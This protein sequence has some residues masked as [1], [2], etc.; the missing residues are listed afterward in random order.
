AK[1]GSVFDCS[2]YIYQVFTQNGFKG[3]PGTSET[4]WATHSGPNWTSTGIMPNSAQPGDVVFMVGSPEYPSPGHVGIVTSG[5]GQNAQV[6]QYYSSG[7]PADTIPMSQI[8][9]MVGIKRFYLVKKEAGAGA[10]TPPAG[11]S[12]AASTASTGASGLVVGKAAKKP[13]AQPLIPTKFGEAI[14]AAALTKGV[15]DDIKAYNSAINEVSQAIAGTKKGSESRTKL[16][17][18]LATY[19]DARNK[20]AAPIAEAAIAK[21]TPKVTGVAAVETA[22]SNLQSGQGTK[23]VNVAGIG[24]IPTVAAWNKIVTQLK[25]K[26]K[27]AQDRLNSL[28]RSLKKAKAARFPNKSL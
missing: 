10:S 26:Y 20:L 3:F 9:D 11:A 28:S 19:E 18:L 25:A 13:K 4:Q 22:I 2:G 6:M 16:E 24:M 5:T 14:S 27:A 1:P 8:G 23:V 12:A 17:K 15:G 7:K 21:A